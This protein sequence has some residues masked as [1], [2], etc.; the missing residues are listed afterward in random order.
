MVRCWSQGNFQVLKSTGQKGYIVPVIDVLRNQQ[1][2]M[3]QINIF[4]YGRQWWCDCSSLRFCCHTPMGSIQSQKTR[5]QYLMYAGPHS[6]ESNPFIRAPLSAIIKH[7]AQKVMFQ[8]PQGEMHVGFHFAFS[9]SG[10]KNMSNK[11]VKSI[12]SKTRGNTKNT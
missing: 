5:P 9:P 1:E 4:I 10:R 11:I 7:M 6:K 8:L 3:E 12:S 2:Q